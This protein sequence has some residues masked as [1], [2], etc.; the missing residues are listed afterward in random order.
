M[1]GAFV[2]CVLLRPGEM[3]IASILK[4]ELLKEKWKQW[5][6]LTAHDIELVLHDVKDFIF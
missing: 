3:E 2:F 4:Y 5:L 6:F 1:L